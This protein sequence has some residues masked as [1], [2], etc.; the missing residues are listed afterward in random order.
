MQP[1]RQAA[2]IGQGL[3]L[4][5]HHAVQLFEYIDFL[6]F[7]QEIGDK[8]FRQRKGKAELQ[9]VH[10]RGGGAHGFQKA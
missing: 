7:F 4:R 5:L 3:Y 10:R 9:H 1:G 6:V 8:F 2:L